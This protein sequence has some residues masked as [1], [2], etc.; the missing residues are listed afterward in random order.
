MTML[1]TLFNMFSGPI[2]SLIEKAI[3]SGVMYMA[4][5]GLLPMDSVAGVAAALYAATSAVFT[6]VTKST[7]GKAMSLNADMTNGLKVVPT[8]TPGPAVNSTAE[9]VKR[10]GPHP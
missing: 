2:S 9:A 5:K 7:T 6:G 1:F 3:L 8:S 4:G 10:G